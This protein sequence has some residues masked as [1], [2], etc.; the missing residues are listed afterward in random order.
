MGGDAAAVRG[1]VAQDDPGGRLPGVPAALGGQPRSKAAIP[2]HSGEELLDVH[3][4]RL[5]LDHEQ[6]P[7]RSV[8]RE[9]IDDSPLSIDRE[10]DLG[11]GQPGGVAT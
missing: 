10:R 4:L 9:D 3:E 6:L 8:E 11:D 2:I 7:S 5:E 1:R